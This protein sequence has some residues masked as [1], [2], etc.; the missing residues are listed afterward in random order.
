LPHQPHAAAGRVAVR[1]VQVRRAPRRGPSGATART[2]PGYWPGTPVPVHDRTVAASS[3]NYRYSVNMQVVI[4]ANTR[5][6]VAVGRPVPGNHNDCTAY[7][8][9]GADTACRGAH[10]MTDGGYQG[11]QQSSCPTGV[12]ATA[13]SRPP[14]STSSTPSANG[15]APASSTPSRT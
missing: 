3:K 10:V 7:R 11:N 9:S 14:G 2:R 15:C 1:G 13:A 12:P 4:D 5:L 8:D 6:A